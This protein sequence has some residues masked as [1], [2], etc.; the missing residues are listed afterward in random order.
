MSARYNSEYT[1]S[2]CS[3]NFQYSTL[4]CYLGKNSTMPPVRHGTVS[5]K[6]V[7]PTYGAIGYDALTHGVQS[8]QSHFNIKDAYG[9]GAS[10]CTP[11]YTTRLC[12]GC[13]TKPGQGMGWRCDPNTGKCGKN[14]HLG[15]QGVFGKRSECQQNCHEV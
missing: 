4:G 8:G 7:V 14:G 15:A 9:N 10:S 6:M 2:G 13:G 11:T 12:G 5:G 1:N 3:N